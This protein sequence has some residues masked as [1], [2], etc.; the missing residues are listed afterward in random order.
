[1][2]EKKFPVLPVSILG[3][4]IVGGGIMISNKPL[5]GDMEDVMK[6]K[7]EREKEQQDEESR[8]KIA[9][10]SRTA[11]SDVQLKNELKNSLKTADTSNMGVRKPKE[12]TPLIT[13]GVRKHI[14]KVTPNDA[15]PAQG[16]YRSNFRDE[17]K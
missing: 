7:Y 8:K 13:T 5:V 2:K 10:D 11:P 17:K 15:V 9:G 16:W 1:M 12:K 6:A 4:M 14:E 3:V